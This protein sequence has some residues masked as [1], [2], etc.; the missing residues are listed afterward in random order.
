MGV[1][2]VLVIG[3]EGGSGTFVLYRCEYCW[4]Y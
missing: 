2:H 3:N 1:W 4:I